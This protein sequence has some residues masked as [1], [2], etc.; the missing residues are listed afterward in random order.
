M[1]SASSDLAV[2]FEHPAWQEPL[3]E[4]LTRRGLSFEPVDLKSATFSGHDAPR[5]PVYFNQ[6]SP[7]AYTRGNTRAVP[8]A[9]ALIEDLEARS[10]RVLN[11]S[12]PFRLE[13]SKMAQV[14]LMR[15][16][17]VPHPRTWAFN[18]ADALRERKSELTFPALLK[19]N[20][21]G[22]GARMI[23]VESLEELDATLRADP[24]LWQPDHLLLL[25][26]HLPHDTDG[27][28]IVRMEYLGGELLYA[29]RV[30]S[31]GN[32]NLC[33]SEVCNPA[34]PEENGATGHDP[35]END[36]AEE[37]AAPDFHPYPDVPDEAV[38]QGARIMAEGGFDAGSVEY[39]VA[40]DGRRVFYDI[41]ANS[42]LRRPVGKAFG[43]DPFERVVDFLQGV[44]EEERAAP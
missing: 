40:E 6:A 17:G 28:G 31:K 35:T 23:R 30:V 5:A 41:N 38:A 1:T 34:A 14:G 29:M 43:F 42:N 19:P 27:H 33:P 44:L 7:S 13:L 11:G 22:S 32:F 10:V 26:E 21:G 20:Q 39:L 9:L 15:R 8:F 18:S 24:S 25:Q 3:F 12:Q 4:A 2:L 36:A 16:L 37:N